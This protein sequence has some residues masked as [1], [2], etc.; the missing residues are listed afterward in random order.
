MGWANCGEDSQ[1]RPIGYAH[2]AT[3]DYPGCN[4]KIN[5]GLSY[6]CGGMHGEDE[7]SCDRYFCEKHMVSAVWPKGAAMHQ[8]QFCPDCH[9]ALVAAGKIDD[10]V[11]ACSEE[12]FLRDVAK[13]KM[14]V[15]HDDGI[16]RHLRF[17][18]P[19]TSIHWFDIVT[20][21]GSLSISGDMGCYVFSRLDDMFQFFRRDGAGDKLYI[22]I[23]YWAEKLE[24]QAY[25]RRGD[26]VKRWDKG[27]FERAIRERYAE[28]VRAEM[29]RIPTAC[30]ELRADIENDLLSCSDDEHAAME[31]AYN[32]DSHGLRFEDFVEVDFTEW[33]THF[34]WC[35][36]AIAWGIR[37][38]DAAPVGVWG[39]RSC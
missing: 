16:Y 7:F 6:A 20:W 17:R 18:N 35:L 14:Y 1:G 12:E 34:I 25:G 23:E 8:S 32:F 21:P 33:T 11:A 13:H 15:M 3:C 28:H 19:D 9:A 39:R 31:A 24:A 37:K 5:R 36:Y 29:S 27:K 38:Y 4:A 22:N 26:S 30:E 10:D 2:E